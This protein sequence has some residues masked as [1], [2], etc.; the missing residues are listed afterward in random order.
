MRKPSAVRFFFSHAGY[1]WNPQ[2]ETP[3]QGRWRTARDLT[4]AEGYANANDWTFEWSDDWA[5]GSH[6]RE[7]GSESYPEEPSTCETCLL[8]DAEGNVLE[9]LGCIDDASA[10]YRRVV[11]AELASEA[12]ASIENTLE[13]ETTSAGDVPDVR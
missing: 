1:S 7:Y 8:R 5:C 10:E 12:L 4:R 3:T 9:S 6:V 13:R 2:T 11:Q